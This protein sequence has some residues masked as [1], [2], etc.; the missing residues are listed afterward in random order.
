MTIM[1]TREPVIECKK[2]LR[3]LKNMERDTRKADHIYHIYHL[4]LGKIYLLQISN[5]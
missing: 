5:I 2:Y 4:F 3:M 1:V